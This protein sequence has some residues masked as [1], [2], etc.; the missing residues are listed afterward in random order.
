MIERQPTPSGPDPGLILLTGAT[1]YVGGRL[2]Q[3]LQ[4][5]DH[6]V[7]CLARRPEFLEPKVGPATEI[8]RG[9]VLD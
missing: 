8:V 6:G 9:D 4:Q 1:G 2:L 3:A 7:R 5:R